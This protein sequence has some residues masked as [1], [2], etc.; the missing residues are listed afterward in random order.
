[1]T[2]QGPTGGESPRSG[3]V[4]WDAD[5]NT[6]YNAI[7]SGEDPQFN[8]V[9]TEF[10]SLG[11]S[12]LGIASE[13]DYDHLVC[14][15]TEP[16]T[17]PAPASIR[18]SPAEPQVAPMVTL[19]R[20]PED[21][22][23]EVL[24]LH[25]DHLGS[26]RVVTNEAGG[27]VAR[28]DFF[29][30][31][32]EISPMADDTTKMFTGHERDRETG[33]DYMFARYYSFNAVRFLSVDKNP[34]FIRFPQNW[35]GY[36]YTDQNPVNRSDPDGLA[37]VSRRLLDLGHPY[38]GMAA[39]IL[40]C[41]P[42][43]SCNGYHEQIFYED[44]TNVGFFNDASGGSIRDDDP[45]LIS[46]YDV[47]LDNLDDDTLKAAE[48]VVRTRG[49]WLGC[50]DLFGNNCQDFVAAVLT[51]YMALAQQKGQSTQAPSPR[52]TPLNPHGECG[53]NICS[54]KNKPELGP[55]GRPIVP[56]SNLYSQ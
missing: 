38:S 7:E 50:Y 13:V 55:K 3:I 1:V 24:D 39:F 53:D 15:A 10:G 16:A 51:E 29:P 20:M 42:G 6:G 8:L 2:A 27:L 19:G 52:V 18:P 22:L 43:G 47:H 37:W 48:A 33:L 17:E 41:L 35:N 12:P 11:E 44:G 4:F 46:W 54:D 21:P 34:A 32:D 28:H 49:N 31:G 14:E 26:T 30:F 23:Y 45:Q 5:D 25:V 9:S 56:G 40:S 36:L